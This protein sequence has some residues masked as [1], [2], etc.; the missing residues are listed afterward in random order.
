MTN[1]LRKVIN[2]FIFFLRPLFKI[3]SPLINFLTEINFEKNL[4]KIQ[5]SKWSSVPG[6]IYKRIENYDLLK[7]DDIEFIEKYNEMIKEDNKSYRA[8]YREK[9]LLNDSKKI[10][11]LGCGIGRDGVFL[12]EKGYQVTFADVVPSNIHLVQRVCKLK[13]LK[14]KF[15]ILEKI[16]DYENLGTFD[17]IIAMG[18]LHHMPMKITKKII[19]KMSKNFEKNKTKFLMLAYPFSRWNKDGCLPFRFW[20]LKTD[21]WAP[22]TE[23]YDRKKVSLVFS[24]K[25]EI[26]DELKIDD[27]F[28]IFYIQLN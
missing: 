18:S 1:F 3:I 11:D 8:I 13:N 25:I 15:V 16:N 22:W 20:G 9:Y 10:L 5:R 28:I 14:C 19:E 27:E 6:T 7:L 12:A 23:Y 4:F 17:L 24:N 21:G 2:K 26:I